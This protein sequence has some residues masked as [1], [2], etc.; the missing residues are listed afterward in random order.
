M[1]L[2]EEVPGGFPSNVIA[3]A[4]GRPIDARMVE[5]ISTSF[6]CVDGREPMDDASLR[7]LGG[8]MGEFINLITYYNQFV[9]NT[10]MSAVEVSGLM[11]AW[12]SVRGSFHCFTTLFFRVHHLTLSN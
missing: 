3:S 4:Y 1:Q 11:D 6:S 9:G 8:D 2:T 7:T 5:V 10:K 12:I